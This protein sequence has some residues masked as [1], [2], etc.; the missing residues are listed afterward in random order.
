MKEKDLHKEFFNWNLNIEKALRQAH[1]IED[2]GNM[3][4]E[5]SDDYGDKPL[6][7]KAGDKETE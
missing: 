7:H 4:D 1:F 6:E 5:I 2:V 3:D